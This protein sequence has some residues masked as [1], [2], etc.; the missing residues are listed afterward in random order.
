MKAWGYIL[1]NLRINQKYNFAISVLSLDEVRELG[2]GE[3]DLEGIAGFL[4]SL[5]EVKGVLFLREKEK[6]L[7]KGSL[8]TSHPDINVAKIAER[9]GGG[10][11]IKASA[12]IMHA[13]LQKTELGWRVE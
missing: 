5:K 10:G 12:F 4:S 2:I 1:A 3:D 9:L 8:R 6:G 11:H 13:D 7:L